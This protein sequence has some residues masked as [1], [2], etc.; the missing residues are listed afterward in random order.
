MGCTCSCRQIPHYNLQQ[1]I[2]YTEEDLFRDVYCIRQFRRIQNFPEICREFEI[3]KKI[4]PDCKEGDDFEIKYTFPIIPFRCDSENVDF[5]V[6]CDYYF[7]DKQYNIGYLQLVYTYDESITPMVKRFSQRKTKSENSVERRMLKIAKMLLE[8]IEKSIFPKSVDLNCDISKFFE[9]KQLL[10]E[11][12][13]IEEHLLQGDPHKA[14]FELSMKNKPYHLYCPFYRYHA[15]F[16]EPPSFIPK[17][18]SPDSNQDKN[19]DQKQQK[20]QSLEQFDGKPVEIE[21][22]TYQSGI[23]S[24]DT[25]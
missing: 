2:P 12:F 18:D 16:S 17:I 3:N 11:T 9:Y 14:I 21:R 19:N 5:L 20:I 4:V 8:P 25:K 23:K 10:L 15:K 7:I 1:D 13:D 6:G 24:N 22:Y